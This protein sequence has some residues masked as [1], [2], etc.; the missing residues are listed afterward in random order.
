M[1]DE[2]GDGPDRLGPHFYFEEKGG[3]VSPAQ[4]PLTAGRWYYEAGAVSAP[5]SPVCFDWG[6]GQGFFLSLVV[7]AQ[8]PPLGVGVAE[9]PVGGFPLFSA[10]CT[11]TFGPQLTPQNG[12]PEPPPSRGWWVDADSPCPK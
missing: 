2:E 8:L 3:A 10:Q 12:S 5:A 11:E 7:L 1:D 6:E 9:W 4:P